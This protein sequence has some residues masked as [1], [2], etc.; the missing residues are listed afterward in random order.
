MIHELDRG[1]RNLRMDGKKLGVS[2]LYHQC[3]QC[4]E[5]GGVVLGGGGLA[6]IESSQVESKLAEGRE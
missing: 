2:S 5:G 4:D 6:D 3:E 1:E